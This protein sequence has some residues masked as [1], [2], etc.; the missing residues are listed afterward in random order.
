ME[1]AELLQEYAGN[2]DCMPYDKYVAWQCDCLKV[3]FRVLKSDGAIFYNH[4]WRVPKG[5][6]QDCPDIADGFPVRQII[7]WHCN[8]GI[9][10]NPCYFL[11]TYEV[12]YLICKQNFKL[13]S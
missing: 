10:F 12:I 4:K 13:S 11:P 7:I 9:N 3:M 8:G 6:L 2:S 5:L 1:N